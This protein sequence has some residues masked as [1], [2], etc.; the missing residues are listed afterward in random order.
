[1]T[2]LIETDEVARSPAW[3]PL[4]LAAPGTL[5][6][7]RLTE[8]AYRAA[9]FLDQRVLALSPE[10]AICEVSVLEAAAAQ[11]A[12]KSHYIFHIG[13]VGSTLVSRLIG[14]HERFFSVREPALLREMSRSEAISTQGTVAAG[15]R[16]TPHE[17]STDALRLEVLLR[18]LART[19]RAEQRAVIK[20]TSFVS[21]L[22][23]PIL[24]HSEEP[25]AIFMFAQPLAYLRTILGGPNSRIEARTLAASRLR[26]LARRLGHADWQRRPTSEGEYLAMSWL[27]EMAA[28]Y[29]GA[30]VANEPGAP[31]PNRLLWVDFDRFLA[32]PAASLAEIL[33]VLGAELT[34][35]PEIEALVAGPL[36]HRYS[37]APEHAYDA[38]L[39]R[40]VLAAADS[41]YGSEVRCGMDWLDGM[42]ARYPLV[43][44]ILE[45]A[46]DH[47]P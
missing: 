39:R 32:C 40:D 26:R 27:C 7:I 44:K 25:A 23:A 31:R 17:R 14:E 33:R 1:M 18:L 42:A 15:G 36:M 10:T 11:L 4:E 21:E 30:S 37:K 46:A 45:H 9:S 8:T 16:I 22:V 2:H 20:A 38:A 29:Q 43:T 13:H 6:L 47:A 24:A 35:V 3:Y 19:W 28:L 34:T 12:P 41:Q 5:R